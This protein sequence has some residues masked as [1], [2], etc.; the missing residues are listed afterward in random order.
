MNDEGEPFHDLQF[1][2][3]VPF[4]ADEGRYWVSCIAV[5]NSDDAIGGVWL[6]PLHNILKIRYWRTQNSSDTKENP[7]VLRDEKVVLNHPGCDT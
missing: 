6:V 4:V 3:P 2:L 5:T 7:F 1:T